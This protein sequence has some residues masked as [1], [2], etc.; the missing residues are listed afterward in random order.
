MKSRDDE[1]RELW[2]E[3][4]H[5]HYQQLPAIALASSLGA[6][7]VAWVLWDA[8]D[9]TFLAAGLIS[10][11]LI[12][13]ARLMLYK[14]YC[15]RGRVPSPPRIW[16]YAAISF[17]LLSGCTWGGVAVFLYP[18]SDPQYDVFLLVLMALV[19]VAP[20]GSLAAYM[21]AFY[22]YYL[23]SVTPFIVVLA[24]YRDLP[25]KLTAL[26]LTAMA[27][28]TVTF[29]NRYSRT[30]AQAIR[31]RL[32]L[33]DKTRQ[34]E[35]ASRI[36]TR[37][38]AAASH[39]LRQPIHAMGLFTELLQNRYQ[40]LGSDGT[41]ENL[42]ES[43]AILRRMLDGLLDISSIDAGSVKVTEKDFPLTDLLDKLAEEYSLLA[44]R[45]GLEFRYVRTKQIARTDPLL[46]ERILRNL[47]D[48]A[49]K[50]TTNGRI[51]LGCRRAGRRIRI[52]VCDN[53]PGIPAKRMDQ[54]FREFTRLHGTGRPG[55][56]G[57]G[58]GLS[59]V[60][61]LAEILDAEIIARSNA[62]S[63]T[64]FGVSIPLGEISSP[65]PGSEPAR[66]QK[67][68]RVLTDLHVLLVDDE[69]PSRT[70]LTAL[71][72]QM[73]ARVTATDGREGA[74]DV[75]AKLSKPP[76]LLVTDYWLPDGMTARAVIRN[77]EAR[78]Q[79]PVPVVIITGD[80]SMERIQEAHASGHILLHKPV[81]PHRLQASIESLFTGDPTAGP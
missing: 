38:L 49:I 52:L 25:E 56:S 69:E 43:L 17:S 24:T 10:I 75:L 11:L 37:I 73:G 40:N 59:I 64:V 27:G 16:V 9:N 60:R 30:L 2:E 35:Q 28:A 1:H 4:L 67:P 34:L 68:G 32:E 47:L 41:F 19:P 21:P 50:H 77:M 31:L 45:R 14:R 81:N 44:A 74:A 26:L 13:L 55:S 57:L 18:P 23:P 65:G 76:H 78:F 46:L 48:N 36:K 70:A 79:A 66:K 72:E 7:L 15:K 29:A 54:V 8:V 20:L 39:D 5:I 33:G 3:Q 51:L 22:A 62:G 61:R 42:R 58:L 53:G 6:S 71:L 80:T 12:S 63:G